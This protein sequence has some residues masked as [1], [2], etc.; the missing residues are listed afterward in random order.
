MPEVRHA[1]GLFTS[2]MSGP[3]H[4]S[5]RPHPSQD[6]Q[7]KHK[8]THAAKLGLQNLVPV[9]G[10]VH[11]QHMRHSA[12][13]RVQDSHVTVTWPVLFAN[14]VAQCHQAQTSGPPFRSTS[15][16]IQLNN[17]NRP[18]GGP[19]RTRLRRL[20]CRRSRRPCPPPCPAP[21]PAPPGCTGPAGLAAAC[22]PVV[23]EGHDATGRLGLA[24]PPKH[25]S[26]TA[27]V[28][29][30][31]WQKCWKSTCH[32]APEHLSPQRSRRAAGHPHRMQRTCNTP[33][34][35]SVSASRAVKVYS[36]G[37]RAHHIVGHPHWLQRFQPVK[38]LLGEGGCTA[39]WQGGWAQGW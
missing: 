9:V 7:H 29:Q 4:L 11:I 2:R 6:Q 22:A 17:T 34:L 33:H 31:G 16:P 5:L 8:L 37:R 19:V 1:D 12:S 25:G 24:K 39:G 30:L 35:Q 38:V 32:A 20:T 26:T 36:R 27:R 23:D 3:S 21:A 18:V 10:A 13:A 14:K 15:Q 28:Q